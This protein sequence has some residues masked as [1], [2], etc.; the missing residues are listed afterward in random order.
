MLIK[1]HEGNYELCRDIAPEL[2]TTFLKLW[3]ASQTTTQYLDF[4]RDMTVVGGRPITRNQ[5]LVMNALVEQQMDFLQVR[6]S[7]RPHVVCMCWGNVSLPLTLSSSPRCL[8]TFVPKTRAR[9]NCR[10][11]RLR[12]VV[13]VV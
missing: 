7:R 6:R 10:K 1:M 11:T 3:S 2:I 4:L 12:V 9:Y 13:W 8:W 5:T